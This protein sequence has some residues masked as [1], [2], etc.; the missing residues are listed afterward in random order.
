MIRR[1]WFPPVLS[2]AVTLIC[3]AYADVSV[4]FDQFVA[5][6]K[7]P[8]ILHEP[9]WSE[10]RANPEA[11][12][13]RL[14]CY[15]LQVKGRIDTG[16]DVRLIGQ[17]RAEAILS[18]D[19]P[20]G[21]REAA[22]GSW[23]GV[24]GLLPEE[25][26]PSALVAVAATR[27]QTPQK[28]SVT[29]MAAAT[30]EMAGGANGAGGFAES[31]PVLGTEPVPQAELEPRP[32]PQVEPRP[33]E[34]MAARPQPQPQATVRAPAPTTDQRNLAIL[35][36]FI[37]SRGS[38]LSAAERRLAAT[39]I[40]TLSRYH[41]MRW[42]FFAA[43]VAAESDYNPRCVSSA[44]AMGLGQLMPFNC[45]EYGVSD[46]F[47]IRQNLRGSADHLR[48]FLDKYR[49]KDPWTQLSL[50][51]ACYNAGPGAVRKYG[52]VPPYR[53]TVN[54]IK[55]VADLYVRLCQQSGG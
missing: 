16:G 26:E 9:D 41:G 47:D 39:E 37:I 53:E 27:V 54:Y 17:N 6:Y 1:W 14:I 13:G 43:M 36:R 23:L 25:G 19:C 29:S 38:P 10:V 11:Y 49:D 8:D 31:E 3:P 24:I 55:K 7:S 12:R 33:A 45:K 20:G 40:L 50:T 4:T 18:V 48:E 46:P 42:E 51:L 2:L 32:A 15:Q 22:L 44:G 21:C 28:S 30:G 35:E 34:Q 5:Q 52:G